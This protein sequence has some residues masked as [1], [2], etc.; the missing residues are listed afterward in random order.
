MTI[1]ANQTSPA[2]PWLN[3]DTLTSAANLL[4][5]LGSQGLVVMAR[6]Y[7]GP[8]AQHPCIDERAKSYGEGTAKLRSTLGYQN[9]DVALLGLA[10]TKLAFEVGELSLHNPTL[11]GNGKLPEFK[12]DDSGRA[13]AL[14]LTHVLAANRVWNTYTAERKQT[15][16]TEAEALTLK[17]QTLANTQVEVIP[18]RQRVYAA[19]TELYASQL[20]YTYA[21]AAPA[22]TM[23]STASRGTPMATNSS[24]Y[25]SGCGC[26][27]STRAA[28]PASQSGISYRYRSQPAP[29]PV[30][31]SSSYRVA[32]SVRAD[33]CQ[34]GGSCG[35]HAKSSTAPAKT[36]DNTACPT[37]A[38]SCETK[39]VLRECVK[40]ALCD[41]LRCLGDTLCPDGKFDYQRLQRRYSDDRGDEQSD[42]QNNTQ[43]TLNTDLINCVGQLACSFM[44][45]I[46]EALCPEPCQP[47][48]L[49]ADN[50]PCD[51]AVETV[52]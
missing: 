13:P 7:L 49:P 21:S 18:A 35:C 38:I 44:H 10:F 39:Q 29:A 28:M 45:C 23:S 48:Q 41:F 47:P 34:C 20:R 31:L 2:I 40:V 22:R 12:L 25:R 6:A 36:Y 11:D 46:P 9:T 16:A 19:R 30:G 1:D 51:Y 17:K 42:Y 50:L 32:P 5:R 26:G 15:Q 43:R 14:S 4:G 8:L 3:K 24:S 33:A 37:F 52:R 27:G